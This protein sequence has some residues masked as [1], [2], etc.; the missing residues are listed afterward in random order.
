M[1]N[2][3][4]PTIYFAP[5]EGVTGYIFRNAFNEIYG[6][7]DKFFAPFISPADKCPITP[8][9]RRDITPENNKN[10]NLVPQIMTCRSDH[11]IETSRELQA[12]GY[13][14]VNLNLGCT[15]SSL[16]GKLLKIFMRS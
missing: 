4:R 5:L 1:P 8:R 14:E 3:T 11:F 15:I 6:H 13:K 2:Q 16:T 9:E 7:V 12:M 10:I